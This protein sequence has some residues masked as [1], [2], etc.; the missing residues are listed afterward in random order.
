MANLRQLPIL[1]VDSLCIHRPEAR[2]R[3][4]ETEKWPS[5]IV[6]AC[7]KVREL[8]VGRNLFEDWAEVLD[9]CRQLPRLTKLRVDGNRFSRITLLQSPSF[10]AITFLGLDDTL[11]AWPQISTVASLFRGLTTLSVCG[12]EYDFL[13]EETLPSSLKVLHLE[14]NRFTSLE[15]VK[16]LAS[17]SSLEKLDLRGNQI[18]M[19]QPQKPRRVSFPSSLREIDL[20]YN[21]LNSWVSIDELGAAFP[22]MA[23]LRI[24]HNPLFQ[25]LQDADGRALLPEDGYMLTIARLGT[26][27]KLNF[28]QVDSKERRDAEVYYLSQIN[29]LLS[30]SKSGDREALLTEHAR[31]EDLCRIYG[32]SA[33]PSSDTKSSTSTVDPRSL[34]ASLITITFKLDAKTA[35]GAKSQEHWIARLPR[36]FTIYTALSFVARHFGLPPMKLQLVWE[37]GED[38]VVQEEL[39]IDSEE[40]DATAA[41]PRHATPKQREDT[42]VPQTRA[43]GTWIETPEAVI[44]VEWS[45]RYARKGT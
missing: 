41:E 7:P 3:V 43:L 45:K 18:S 10:G 6:D 44:R 27:S 37:T 31:Y 29:K 11:L 17:A 39:D 30:G 38:D 1:L 34:E 9:I 40:E 8:D 25:S 36:S 42:L 16:P 2:S 26:L 15:D 22:G 14:R 28:S 20:A 23:S 35:A 32:E 24:S 12:N 5:E 19:I 21:E 4:L 33:L 13:T